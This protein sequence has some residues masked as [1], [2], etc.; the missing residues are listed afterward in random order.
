MPTLLT[1]PPAASDP[2]STDDPESSKSDPE[3]S[4]SD[5]APQEEERANFLDRA[6][7]AFT[8]KVSQETTARTQ[9]ELLASL[10]FQVEALT[11]ENSSLLAENA[12]L[13][14]EKDEFEKIVA[15]AEAAKQ[16]TTQAAT[17]MV[18][19][20]GIPQ[21]ELPEQEAEGDA[22]DSVEGLQ[23][24]IEASSDPLEQGRLAKQLREL[25]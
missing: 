8:S 5:P 24:R 19:A 18:A 17:D 14:N 10:T 21:D 7:A 22:A 16:T 6:R 1:P 3:S 2:P 25:R 4:K 9:A 13:K 11:A 23:K 15:D 20:T 12:E